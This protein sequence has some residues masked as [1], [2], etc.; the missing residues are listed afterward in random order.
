M[1]IRKNR[2]IA[3]IKH[4]MPLDKVPLWELHFH[5]W[6]QYSDSTFISGTE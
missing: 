3:A 5:L 6:N 2:M 4:E 1:G